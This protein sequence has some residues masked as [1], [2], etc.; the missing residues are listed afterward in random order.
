MKV[1]TD[2]VLD[3]WL[4]PEAQRNAPEES[5]RKRWFQKDAAFDEEIRMM[6]GDIIEHAGAGQLDAWAESPRGR[7]ALVILL[8]Q[9]TRNVYRDS[10]QMYAHDVHAVTMAEIGI[11]RGE[12]NR[13]AMA[14]RYFLYMP[15]MHA[16]DRKRQE[17]CVVLF[18]A[19]AD[20]AP[21][22]AAA[23]KYARAHRDIVARFGRF[24]HRNELLGR[25]STA[26]EI[27]FLKQPGSS[28]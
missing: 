4:G 1:T 10:P 11:D 25:T 13:L 14:E 7:L 8:D 16:E 3:F 2:D 21:Q 6:F 19:L 18:E 22:F 24:P 23:L 15:L 9:F 12:D 5:V 26:E 28:F 20:V 27:E 17:R